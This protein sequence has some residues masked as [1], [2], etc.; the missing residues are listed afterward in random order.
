MR[1]DND[2]PLTSMFRL[3]AYIMQYDDI[4]IYTIKNIK[5]ISY[6]YGINL[7]NFSENVMYNIIFV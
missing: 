6:A 5:E 1:L 3:P 4:I 7:I 2:I